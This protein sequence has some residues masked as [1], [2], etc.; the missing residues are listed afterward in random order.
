[1]KGGGGADTFRLKVWNKATGI[2]I[3]DN[4]LGV[5]DTADPTTALGGGSIVIHN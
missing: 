4:Q 1:M 5:S 3:Y 2:S